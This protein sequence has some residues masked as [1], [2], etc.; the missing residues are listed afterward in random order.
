L[1]GDNC[2]G[3]CGCFEG[4]ICDMNLVDVSWQ[5]MIFS[6]HIE[7]FISRNVS[8]NFSLLFIGFLFL[9]LLFIWFCKNC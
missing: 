7:V 3:V 8:T 1:F 4:H 5:W 6:N 9:F 2:I